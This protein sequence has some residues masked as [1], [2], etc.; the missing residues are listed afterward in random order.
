MRWAGKCGA[1][2]EWNTLEERPKPS[3]SA[4]RRLSIVPREPMV[5]LADVPS[6]SSVRRSTGIAELDLVLGG[7]LV[8]GS[9]TLLGG[10]PG[11]GKSTLLL[12]IARTFKGRIFYFSG[13]E[14]PGQI[15]M[16]ADRMS[17][18]SGRLFVSRESQLDSLLERVEKERPDLVFVDSIQTLFRRTPAVPGSPGHL[19][20][21]AI[22]LM[23]A[24]K[25]TRIPIITTGHLTKDG[26]V[27]GPRLLEHMVDTVLYFESDRLNHYRIVRSVKNRFGPAGEIAFFE[28]R[29]SGLGQVRTVSRPMGENSAGR[30]VSAFI[31]GS[32]ALAVEVQALVVRASYGPARRTADGLDNRRL[33]LLAA[34]LEKVLRTNLGDRD[35]F[36][37]LAGGLSSHDP[38]L[39]LA[40]C[41]S[42]L[43]S[44]FE[45]PLPDHAAFVGEVGLSGEVRPVPRI[46]DRI[47]ELRN[48]G[49]N[50]IC[51]P[52]GSEAGREG[53]SF[54]L[55][56]SIHDLS[57]FFQKNGTKN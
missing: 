37:N 13:E 2:G 35:I 47:K 57:T 54:R 25:A 30:A 31:E 56:R 10:E 39:D 45:E 42:V 5:A 6:D 4:E 26:A 32:R 50:T 27:A 46:H 19:R 22:A 3:P 23:Q 48:L 24:A 55:V 43:S 8:P 33:V 18:D 53:T 20:E 40:V 12:E 15:R 14:S 51:L 9:L 29:S 38:A 1:C 21:A 11:I 44:L 41:A 34:V 28:M 52:E 7:G 16:R 36:V 17:V 49:F